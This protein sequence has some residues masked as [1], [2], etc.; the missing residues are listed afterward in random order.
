VKQKL[1][2]EVLY[3]IRRQC[4]IITTESVHIYLT[5]IKLLIFS[6]IIISNLFFI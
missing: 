6:Y 3:I 2:R 4:L 5:G 1:D